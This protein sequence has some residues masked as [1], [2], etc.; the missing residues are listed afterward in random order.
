MKVV[1]T[2]PCAVYEAETVNV[3]EHDE[4]PG[5][6][7]FRLRD[8]KFGRLLDRVHGISARVG[9]RHDRCLRRLERVPALRERRP[10]SQHQEQDKRG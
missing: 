5:Q 6:R 9:E 1:A 7:L 4:E 2:S 3:V 10:G 8:A